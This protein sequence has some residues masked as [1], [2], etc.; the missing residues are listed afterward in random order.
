MVEDEGDVFAAPTRQEA[1]AARY[2]EEDDRLAL[3]ARLVRPD[4]CREERTR[5]YAMSTSE[6][7]SLVH[8]T[9][10]TS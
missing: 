6:L 10:E 8:E 5:L 1:A 7:E 3:L 9:F 2:R 4:T